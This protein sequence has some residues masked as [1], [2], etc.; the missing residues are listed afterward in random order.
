MEVSKLSSAQLGDLNT[1]TAFA[2]LSATMSDL[3]MQGL[4]KHERLNSRVYVF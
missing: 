4:F 1:R 3:K 2:E